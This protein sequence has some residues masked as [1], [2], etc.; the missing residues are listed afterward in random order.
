MAKKKLLKTLATKKKETA[1]ISLRLE[2]AELEKISE[3]AKLYADGNNSEWIRYAALN[4]E[5]SDD[6]LV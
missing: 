4:F 2:K 1:T 6:D 3:K 5:P